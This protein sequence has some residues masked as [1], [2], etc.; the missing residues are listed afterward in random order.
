L[1]FMNYTRLENQD[2]ARLFAADCQVTFDGCNVGE[3]AQ[4]EYFLVEI[5]RTLLINNGGRVRGNIAGGFGYWGNFEAGGWHPFGKWITAYS[6]PGGGARLSENATHLRLDFLQAR[7]ARLR[8]RVRVHP[9]WFRAAEKHDIES[10][11]DQ[12]EMWLRGGAGWYASAAE[13]R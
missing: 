6:G 4:G 5:A 10:A 2:F 12:A 7:I 9:N 13:G 3:G 11:A 8:D 1:N